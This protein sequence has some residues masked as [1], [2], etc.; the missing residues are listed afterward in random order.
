MDWL[1]ELFKNFGE[2]LY[3][4]LELG[5]YDVMTFCCNILSQLM[6]LVFGSANFSGPIE[7]AWNALSPEARSAAV[8][9]RIPT[10]VGIYA[11][12]LS[13]RLLRLLIPFI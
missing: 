7:N 3:S 12:A 5:F 4:F 6:T 11:S 1:V 10:I 9:F 8:F 2:Y 13:I